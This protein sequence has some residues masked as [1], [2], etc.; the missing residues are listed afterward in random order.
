MTDDWRSY[1][2]IAASYEALWTPRFVTV[3]R[4]LLDL[5]PPREGSRILDL[6]AGTGA[7]ARALGEALPAVNRMV[8]CDLSFAMLSQA[9]FP[10]PFCAVLGNMLCLPLRAGAFDLVTANC[11]LSHVDDHQ[12][13]LREVL[14]VLD[15]P[16]ALLASSWVPPAEDPAMTAWSQLLEAAVGPGTAERATAAVSPLETFFSVPENVHTSLSGAGFD[17]VRI[18]EIG[19]SSEHNVEEYVAERSLNAPGRLA[20]QILGQAGWRAFSDRATA[21]FRRRFGDRIGFRRQ[22]LLAAAT[23]R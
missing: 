15:R 5:A 21:E 10:P 9:R 1:D 20:R 23:V 11:V 18:D 12:A 6:G 7:V 4:H 17:A 3:A 2:R 16:G 22:V 14:R 19:Y 13:A 8:S